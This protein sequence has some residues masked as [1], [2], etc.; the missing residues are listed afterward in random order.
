MEIISRS[1]APFG[2][3]HHY[4][5]Q[6]VVLVLRLTAMVCQGNKVLRVS[7]DSKAIQ[8]CLRLHRLVGHPVLLLFRAALAVLL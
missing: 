1:S 3:L 8:G 6:V 4:L 2:K 7:L 5:A